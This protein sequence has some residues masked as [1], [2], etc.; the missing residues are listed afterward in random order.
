MSEIEAVT[1]SHT[2]IRPKKIR[3]DEDKPEQKQQ[4]SEQQ[5]ADTAPD[6]DPKGNQNDDGIQHI[7][8]VV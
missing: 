2:I 1:V 8:E 4:Q 5:Q 7:D 6:Q 3:R